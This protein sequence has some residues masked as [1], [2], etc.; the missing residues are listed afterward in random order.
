MQTKF[1]IHYISALL[2]FVVNGS[3]VSAQEQ[4]APVGDNR[5]AMELAQKS[6]MVQ[7]AYRYLLARAAKIG[8]ERLRKETRDAI[9]NPQTCIRHR[10]GLSA[11][12]EKQIVEDLLVLGLA[13]AKDNA[14]YPGGLEAG[15]FP[16]VLDDGSD[17]PH[18]PQPFS[19]A[20]GG[21][22]AGHHS[23]H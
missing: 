19:S 13:D 2:F 6:P 8:D 14:A 17:C 1:L 23:Y 5:H 7:S 16:P 15:I 9:G 10:A 20:P 12:G 4:S 22:F 21:S 18:L 3:V 11:E